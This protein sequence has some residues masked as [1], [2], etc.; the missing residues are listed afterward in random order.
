[1]SDKTK[2]NKKQKTHLQPGRVPNKMKVILPRDQN[3]HKHDTKTEGPSTFKKEML[4]SLWRKNKKNDIYLLT[5][6]GKFGYLYV[7]ST[8][9]T[10]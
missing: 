6:K 2:K 10:S 3:A 9:M 5:T 1:M 7:V 4:S 8:S